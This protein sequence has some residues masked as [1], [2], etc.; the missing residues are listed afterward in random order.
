MHSVLLSFIGYIY[1]LQFV[2]FVVYDS[3]SPYTIGSDSSREPFIRIIS[4]QENF[5]QK[6]NFVKCDWPTI[7]N[8]D[9]FEKFFVHRNVSW[10]EMSLT[11]TVGI[12]AYRLPSPTG[13]LYRCILRFP[14]HGFWI[15]QMLQGFFPPR[16]F[17]PVPTAPVIR[18]VRRT[19]IQI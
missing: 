8:N 9:I 14:S 7:L 18:L 6:V 4:I 2:A 13:T 10:V 1:T 12:R 11:V 3:H 19:L 15:S 16:W 5:P 17:N